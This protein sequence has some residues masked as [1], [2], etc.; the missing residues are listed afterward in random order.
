[1]PLFFMC[2]FVSSKLK[3]TAAHDFLSIISNHARDEHLSVVLL[4]FYEI[5]LNT[6]YEQFLYLKCIKVFIFCY[7]L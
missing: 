5:I 6:F 7:L 4:L 3:L 2:F 1:M